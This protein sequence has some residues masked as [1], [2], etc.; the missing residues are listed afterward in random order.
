[1]DAP[2]AKEDCR[3][4]VRIAETMAIIGLNVP[5]V[6]QHDINNGFLL[7]TDFGSRCYLDV[8]NEH[9]AESMYAEALDALLVLQHGDI[10]GAALPDFDADL[11]MSEMALFRDWLLD[12]H[13]RLSLSLPEQAALQR[14]FDYLSASALE[15]PQVWVHRDYHSRNL[16]VTGERNP[17]I[18]D[19]QDAVVGPITYDLVS[20]LRDCYIVWPQSR[21]AEWVAR[22]YERLRSSELLSAEVELAQFMRWFDLMGIQ[23]HLKAAG[24]F[25]RLHHRDGKANYLN[26]IPRTLAYVEQVAPHYPEFDFLYRL[27]EQRVLPALKV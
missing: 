6:F 17:G 18:I 11:L 19:F 25:A 16:M 27:I 15:Q 13:L 20:L 10:A 2:P 1:M 7:L 3:P 14:C 4:F 8:L 9:N 12:T 5:T 26:D 22:Y 21:V 24:I 23:R